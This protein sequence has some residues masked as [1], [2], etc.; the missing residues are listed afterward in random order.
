MTIKPFS[1]KTSAKILKNIPSQRQAKKYKSQAPPS[2]PS[3]TK[4]VYPTPWLHPSTNS[5]GI[6]TK[7][8]PSISSPTNHTTNYTLNSTTEH[9][10]N[11]KKYTKDNPSLSTL[12]MPKKGTSNIIASYASSTTEEAVLP[13][14]YSQNTSDPVSSKSLPEHGSIHSSLTTNPFGASTETQIYSPKMSELLASLK[15]HPPSHALS[16]SNPTPKILPPSTHSPLPP[17]SKMSNASRNRLPPHA[18]LPQK[19]TSELSKV[20]THAK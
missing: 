5:S 12:K 14:P 2:L 13:P 16:M 6:H 4:N 15:D 20:P 17:S 3:S 19:I 8:S 18:P 7:P 1:S 11:H 10:P 9:T